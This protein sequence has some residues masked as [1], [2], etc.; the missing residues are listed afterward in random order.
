M[1]KIEAIIKLCPQTVSKAYVINDLLS[2]KH[3]FVSSDLI[4]KSVRLRNSNT[5]LDTLQILLKIPNLYRRLLLCTTE[6]YLNLSRQRPISYRHQ[7]IDM[8]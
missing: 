7:S 6:K 1:Q 2:D 5:K 8:I 4:N 3:T